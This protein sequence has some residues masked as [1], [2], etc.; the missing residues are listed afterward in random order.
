MAFARIHGGSDIFYSM[1]TYSY[2]GKSKFILFLRKVHTISGYAFLTRRISYKFNNSEFPIRFT[3]CY[4]EIDL[5]GVN[6]PPPAVKYVS[7]G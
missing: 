1:E 6:S 2:F 5:R 7:K 4:T 3:I